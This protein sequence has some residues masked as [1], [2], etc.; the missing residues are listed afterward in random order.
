VR[1]G[2]ERRGEEGREEEIS[3]YRLP[4]R[5]C[6]CSC[7][8]RVEFVGWGR[9]RTNERTNEGGGAVLASARATLVRT[10]QPPPPPR[11]TDV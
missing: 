7:F 6:S 2:E 11:R 9:E 8:V 1:R 10:V 5:S 4:F 3:E